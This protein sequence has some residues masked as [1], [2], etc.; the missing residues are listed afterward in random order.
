MKINAYN[1]Q[2]QQIYN[3]KKPGSVKMNAAVGKADGVVISNIGREF[4]VAKQ[5]VAGAPD[6]RTDITEPIRAAVNNGTYEVSGE[7]FADKLLR[8]AGEI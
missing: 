3:T 4:Q 2:V 7:K 1:M 8:A 5:A 6:I